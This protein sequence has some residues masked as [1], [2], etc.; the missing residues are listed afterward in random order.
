MQLAT[1]EVE[2]SR[3]VY[4]ALIACSQRRHRPLRRRLPVQ[5]TG[6]M[7]TDRGY[8]FFNVVAVLRPGAGIRQAQQELDSVAAHL[9][10][11]D[12]DDVG[13]FRAA[14][15]QELLTGPVRPVLY[16]LFGALSLVL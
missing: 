6:E 9:P 1:R 3:I 4:S 8:H 2:R 15:Y 10:R 11:K 16:G 12:S 5:P 14:P 13:R 7:L